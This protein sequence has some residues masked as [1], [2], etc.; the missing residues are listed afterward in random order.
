MSC[1]VRAAALQC[2]LLQL[3]REREQLRASAEALQRPVRWINRMSP[4]AL[5]MAPPLLR[6][7]T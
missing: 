5:R 6:L 2:L 1:P 4:F 7:K 3:A